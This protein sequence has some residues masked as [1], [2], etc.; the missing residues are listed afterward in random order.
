MQ[1]HTHF[2]AVTSQDK[3]MWNKANRKE[4]SQ[5]PSDPTGTPQS[6]AKTTINTTFNSSNDYSETHKSIHM[7]H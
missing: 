7:I 1:K 5:L 3:K 6:E 2:Y 4:Q